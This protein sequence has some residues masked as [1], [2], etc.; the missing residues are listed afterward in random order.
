MVG[1][2]V[3]LRGMDGLFPARAMH[4]PCSVLTRLEREEAGWGKQRNAKLAAAGSNQPL[5]Q[6]QVDT[7]SPRSWV[8]PRGYISRWLPIL[9]LM[10]LGG[11]QGCSMACVLT[12]LLSP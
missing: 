6:D 2:L 11:R 1:W 7:G 8:P 5:L 10:Q 12:V 3:A 9:Y 4:L